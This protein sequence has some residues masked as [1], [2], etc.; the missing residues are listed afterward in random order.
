LFLGCCGHTLMGTNDTTTMPA[1]TCRCAAS[2]VN[3]DPLLTVPQIAAYL[4]KPIR[5]VY[6]MREKRE[7][8]FVKDGHKLYARRSVLDRWIEDHRIPAKAA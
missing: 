6:A 4:N 8:E 3:P 1:C 7:I 5:T 2:V